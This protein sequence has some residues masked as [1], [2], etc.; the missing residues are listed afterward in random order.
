MG[1]LPHITRFVGLTAD[2]ITTGVLSPYPVGD[3]RL[4]IVVRVGV[5][6]VRPLVADRG[7]GAAKP[8][9]RSGKANNPNIITS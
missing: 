1:D 2:D 6:A 7:A 4:R 9:H 3:V 8:Y 5:L